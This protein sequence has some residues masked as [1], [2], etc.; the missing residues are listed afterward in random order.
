MAAEMVGLILVAILCLASARTDI[1]DGLVPNK[2]LI[3]FAGVAVIY[4]VIYYGLFAPDLIMAFA[5]DAA[6]VS[7]ISLALFYT[8]SFAGGDCKLAIVLSLLFPAG[9]YFHAWGT[10][11]TLVVAL[12]LSLVFGYIYLLLN[13]LFLLAKKKAVI[14]F[15][16]IKSALL[17][18]LGSYFAALTYIAALCDLAMVGGLLYSPAGVWAVR[19][20]S[21]AVALSLPRLEF[22]KSWKC[23]IPVALAVVA[24]SLVTS[25]IPITLRFDNIVR[26]LILFLCQATIRT[27]IYERVDVDDLKKGMILTSISSMLMQASITPGLPGISTEDLR[28]R[29]S[30]DEVNSV[31]LWARATKTTSLAIVKKVPFAALLGAGFLA[32]AVMGALQWL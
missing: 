2:L 13:A 17:T 21:V 8:H 11:F 12:V 15:D 24:F 31:R 23:V 22:L 6:V 1:K 4:D 9:C 19:I 30:D 26:V 5:A 7:L 32:Y 20:S 18:F 10:S 29:L 16:Y 3:P 14:S 27:T 28:S 25:T